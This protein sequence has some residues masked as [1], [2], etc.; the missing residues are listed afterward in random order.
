MPLPLLFI[1]VGI[2]SAA[3]GVGK[4]VKAGIDMKDASDINKKAEKFQF[5]SRD[6]ACSV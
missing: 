3:L 1:G 6:G 2:A 4:G 5:V